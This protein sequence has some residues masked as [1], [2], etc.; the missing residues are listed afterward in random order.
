MFP[1]HTSGVPKIIE[2]L[3]R[4]FD[5]MPGIGPKSAARLAFYWLRVPVSETEGFT[6]VLKRVKSEIKRCK[7]CFNL[8]TDDTCDIC[9]DKDRNQNLICVVEDALDLIAIER[10]SKFDGVY[11]V[12]EGVISPINRVEPEDLTIDALIER[13]KSKIPQKAGTKAKESIVKEKSVENEKREKRSME[14][15]SVEVLIATNPTME[16]EATAMYIRDQLKE[17]SGVKVSRLA[18]GLPSGADLEYADQL[19]IS[20]ALE[21][22]SR[23]E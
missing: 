16:G 11:H 19:T 15:K 6:D 7:F 5:R 12:L 21:Q 4:Y 14:K 18:Q 22:R 13:V 2:E 3:I 17:L 8:S 10:S 20:R 9:Q 23:Y 1:K